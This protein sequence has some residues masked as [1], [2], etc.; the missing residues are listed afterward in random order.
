MASPQGFSSTSA[1]PLRRLRAPTRVHR[2][3]HAHEPR[4]PIPDA[5]GAPGPWIGQATDSP[6]PAQDVARRILGSEWWAGFTFNGI[7]RIERNSIATRLLEQLRSVSLVRMG[8]CSATD[9]A[10]R[11]GAP[12]TSVKISDLITWHQQWLG[13]VYAWAGRVRIRQFASSAITADII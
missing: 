11:K 3:A 9:W 2:Q 5:H 10:S 7:T 12:G 1:N 13:S 4:L 6:A 8:W